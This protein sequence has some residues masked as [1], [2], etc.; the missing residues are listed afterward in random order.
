MQGKEILTPTVL[1]NKGIHYLT[2][3][4]KVSP[5]DGLNSHQWPRLLP[6]LFSPVLGI[7]FPLR[8]LPHVFEVAVVTP[9]MTIQ[10]NKKKLSLVV[11]S[12]ER[13]HFPQSATLTDRLSFMFHSRIRRCVVA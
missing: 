11:L 3:R 10:R 7:S 1:H 9:D 8:L 6:S 12:Q 5:R 4:G 13:G 2:S